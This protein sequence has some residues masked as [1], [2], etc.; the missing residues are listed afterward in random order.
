MSNS[1]FWVKFRTIKKKLKIKWITTALHH[2]HLPL[3]IPQHNRNQEIIIKKT[4]N[5]G[6][7]LPSHHT[8]KSIKLA[9][10]LAERNVK[11]A[12][13]YESFKSKPDLTCWIGSAH[14]LNVTGLSA[15]CWWCCSVL[16]IN[17]S[18]SGVKHS[19]SCSI[20]IWIYIFSQC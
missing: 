4:F 13:R 6:Q 17:W 15:V 19:T 1:V 12:W 11:E 10:F 9:L 8:I 14:G 20:L 5:N 16:G 2:F 18:V 3:K 7:L